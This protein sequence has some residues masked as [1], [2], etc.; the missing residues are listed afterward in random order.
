MKLC[1]RM[2]NPY[3]TVNVSVHFGDNDKQGLLLET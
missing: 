3:K 2:Q 1:K